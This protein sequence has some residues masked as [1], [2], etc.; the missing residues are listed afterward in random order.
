M[1]LLIVIHV[2]NLLYLHNVVLQCY[3]FLLKLEQVCTRFQFFNS[4]QPWPDF[5]HTQIWLEQEPDLPDKLDKLILKCCISS[6]L[7]SYSP[8]TTLL[9]GAGLIF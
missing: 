2:V 5:L 1:I 4:G 6:I 3:A 9:C 7:L 8:L